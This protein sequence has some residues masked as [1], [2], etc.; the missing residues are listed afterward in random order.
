MPHDPITVHQTIIPKG[1]DSDHDSVL[2]DKYIAPANDEGGVAF[3]RYKDKDTQL[4]WQV[5]NYLVTRFPV[6]YE[7]CVESDL[8]QGV[9]KISIPVLMGVCKWMAINL[10]TT[11]LD[12]GVLRVAGE[13]LERY[14]LPRDKFNLAMFL[15]ARE[16][17]SALVVPGRKVPG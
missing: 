7:W 4:K 1:R 15:D 12:A 13:I 6:G 3:D 17:H 5:R 11:D 14:L 2:L 8:A 9:V 10:H 16:K